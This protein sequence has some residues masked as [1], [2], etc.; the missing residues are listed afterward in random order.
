MK[1]AVLLGAGG[2]GCPA[3]LALD[4]EARARAFALRLVIVDPD[5]VDR[6]N[7][8]RQILYTDADVGLFKAEVA[9]RKVDAEAVVG[10]FDRSDAHDLLDAADVLIDGTDD[11]ETR[12]LANDEALKRPIP[13][14]HGAALG[15]TGHLLT[16]LPGRTGCLRCL[17]EGPPAGA[18]TCAEAGVL[19][20]LCG[21]VG[22]AMA[23]A[24]MQVLLGE[25]EAG[26]LHRWDALRGTHRP[27]EVKK[28]RACVACR[29]VASYDSGGT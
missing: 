4:E 1:T 21:V 17:F 28:D 14:V 8:A 2:L 11:F 20:P 25:P 29:A 6:S 22:T 15:W 9:A 16:V 10:R 19:S 12:F 7:L 13:L 23:R 27:L 24:A 26:V 18:P 5:R 3:A